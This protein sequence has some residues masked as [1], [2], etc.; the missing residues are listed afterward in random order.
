MK[1]QLFCTNPACKQEVFEVEVIEPKLWRIC[2]DTGRTWQIA[3]S[4][5]ICPG[6]AMSLEP[7]NEILLHPSS[8]RPKENKASI[9]I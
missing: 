8:S 9:E 6:C 3:A 1:K 7:E 2:Q 4:K 5:P